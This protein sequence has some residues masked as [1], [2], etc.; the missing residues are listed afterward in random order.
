MI[1]MRFPWPAI[2]L[3][4]FFSSRVLAHDMRFE[5][6]AGEVTTNEYRSFIEHLDRQLPPTPSNNLGNVMA[7]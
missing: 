7:Y 3:L 1:G 2:L 4:I 5:S 6:V